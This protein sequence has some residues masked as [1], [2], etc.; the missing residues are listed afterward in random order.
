M[1]IV[2][3]V[4]I[5]LTIVIVVLAVNKKKSEPEKS[6]G[7]SDSSDQEEGDTPPADP[8]GIINLQYKLNTPME[9]QIISDSYDYNEKNK[10]LSIFINDQKLNFTRKV[11]FSDIN[12]TVKIYITKVS[13]INMQKTKLRKSVLDDLKLIIELARLILFS[14][15]K[16]S[17]NLLIF[18]LIIRK[19]RHVFFF[20]II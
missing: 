10:Y 16:S 3:L 1:G 7:G 11:K 12:P 19:C 15:M 5:I 8:F 17:K 20:Q 9:T 6:D 13:E 18:F 4:V 2:V 14:S